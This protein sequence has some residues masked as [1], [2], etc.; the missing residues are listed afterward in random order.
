MPVWT[1]EETMLK[2]DFVYLIKD[3]NNCTK[4]GYSSRDPKKRLKQI[5][6]ANPVAVRLIGVIHGDKH[7]EKFLHNK[8]KHRKLRHSKTEW[9]DLDNEEIKWILEG[10]ELKQLLSLRRLIKLWIVGDK[11]FR[12]SIISFVGRLKSAHGAL[13]RY[14]AKEVMT[15]WAQ[16]RITEILEMKLVCADILDELMTTER[17]TIGTTKQAIG[18]FCAELYKAHRD[19]LEREGVLKLSLELNEKHI[20]IIEQ[21]TET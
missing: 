8:F 16:D 7:L 12:N 10:N 15:V 13:L 5:Q 1:Q 4:I 17:F 20:K 6:S 14:K 3:D 19:L 18:R 2:S 21:H 9:F 11:A